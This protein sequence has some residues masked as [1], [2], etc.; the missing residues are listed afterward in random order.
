MKT[1]TFLS[2]LKIA[3]KV[4]PWLY[5]FKLLCSLVLRGLLLLTP[6]LLGN[7][8]NELSKARY[9][10]AILILVFLAIATIVYRLTEGV[11]NY[12]YHRLYN[13]QYQTNYDRYL[14]TTNNNSIFSL[15]R[16]TMGEYSNIVINDINVVASFYTNLVIRFVQILEF[17]FIYSYFL[18]LN[19]LLFIIVI[20]FSLII[21]LLSL[22]SSKRLQKL[23]NQAKLNLDELVSSTNEYFMGV[24]EI[25]SFNIFGKIHKYLSS[26]M[27]KY[28]LANRKYSNQS[29]Y[30]NQGFL[31]AWE[32]VR[33]ASIFYSIIL[34]KG[35]HLEIG[36]ILIIYNYYQ[37]IIDNFSMILTINLDYRILNI[38]LSRL[39]K[40]NEFSKDK[41]KEKVTIK[42][43]FNGQIKFKNILYGYKNNPT[44]DKVSFTIPANSIT[45]LESKQS[46][47]KSGVFDLLLKLN[48]QHEGEIFLDDIDI[49][50]IS[51]EQYFKHLSISREDPFFFNMSVKDNLM[52]I[53]ENYDTILTICKK[54][55]LDEYLDNIGASY[56]VQ[57][58]NN[59]NFNSV[60]RQLLSI[61]RMLV[62]DSKIMFFD[63]GID[64]LDNK[65]KQKLI[66]VIKD[67]AKDH[68][69]VISTHDEK[70]KT[71]A[72]KTITL[73]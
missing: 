16:F 58:N 14:S 13:K 19:I 20:V 28:L 70:I 73:E 42:D 47:K 51:D 4:N 22:K 2:E 57:I 55:G 56:N 8:I 15:S 59:P 6:I 41:T 72:D 25:K 30:F 65:S 61:A 37:K 26:K 32:L 45:V 38:S 10:N 68:T 29:T 40:I 63:E 48:K 9:E 5:T 33:I 43:C 3:I 36:V 62:K 54:I 11:N 52:L 67:L 66:K 21:F 34:L 1:N 71:L 17:I 49:N 35:G 39:Y 46:A 18:K 60:A 27:S 69:I 53:D 44:L 12:V 31:L 24:K 7:F 64:L 23:N 50:D